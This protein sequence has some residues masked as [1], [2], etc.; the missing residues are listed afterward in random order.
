MKAK[1]LMINDIVLFNGKPRKV[2]GCIEEGYSVTITFDNNGLIMKDK[3]TPINEVRPIPITPE[4]L[5]KNGFNYEGGG[6][7][8]FIPQKR[9]FHNIYKQN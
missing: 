1:E 3:N 5:E 8:K 7:S 2:T 6:Y 4:I 9:T